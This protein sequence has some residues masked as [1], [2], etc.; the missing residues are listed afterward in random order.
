MRRSDWLIL[1]LAAAP[2]GPLDPV[3]V[4][5]GMFL[6]AMEAPLDEGERYDFEPYAYGPMSRE[7]YR[8]V[9]RLSHERRLEEIPIEGATWHLL[10]LTPAGEAR[11][12]RSRQHAARNRPGALARLATI[13][14]QISDLNF[15]ELLERGYDRYPEYAVNSVF[16]RPSS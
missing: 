9:R 1:L 10:Q 2:G 5:K 4:Q 7:L 3:R 16:R 11:A 12:E 15:S 6:L 14:E 13:R 8:D